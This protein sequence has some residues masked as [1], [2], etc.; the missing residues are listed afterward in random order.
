[1]DVVC[2]ENTDTKEECYECGKTLPDVPFLA[3]VRFATSNKDVCLCP[4][5]W[6]GVLHACQPK[7]HWVYDENAMDWGI[8]AWVCD[9]CHGK[10]D[11]IPTHIMMGE[12]KEPITHEKINPMQYAGS[13]FCPN[14]GVLMLGKAGK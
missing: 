6:A 5:C 2:I 9:K 8:G 11:M 3:R 14:C 1:M 10:N 12:G 7:G 4:T 13:R